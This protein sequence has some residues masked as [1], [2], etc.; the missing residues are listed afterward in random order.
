V[1]G[2]ALRVPP[3]RRLYAYAM[4]QTR[5][6]Q[7]YAAALVA[8]ANERDALEQ[9]MV[10]KSSE[11]AAV[12]EQRDALQQRMAAKSGEL[13]AAAEEREALEQRMAVKSSELT[14]AAEERDALEL[15]LY[16]LR[17]DH[18]R[19]AVRNRELS[20]ALQAAEARADQAV[21]AERAR[22]GVTSQE[23]SLL[24]VKLAGRMTLLSSEIGRLSHSPTAGGNRTTLYLDLL[25]RALTGG[26]GADVAIDPWTKGYDPEIGLVRMRN[27]RE[28]AERVIREGVPGDM[29]QAGVWRGGAGILMRGVLAAHGITDRTI[30][31]ADSFAG[32]PTADPETY[33]ADAGDHHAGYDARRV[34]S[35]DVQAN[36]RRYGL[37][38]RQV[39]FLKGWFA[40]TLSATPI[41]RLAILRIDGDMYAS[42]I[43]T[44]DAL[45]DKVEPGGYVIVDDYVLAGCRQAVNDFRDCHGIHDELNDVD[46]SA[47]FWRKA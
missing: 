44:L 16:V 35:E 27:L 31:V 21:A 19:A 47:V 6:N 17:S 9:R 11:L 18:Q 30:W 33:P 28:L 20:A 32:L 15:Q 43:Q 13:A 46:G 25:E 38:D 29:L 4:Q 37:L 8:A 23:L 22:A 41:D 45:Y 24:Y 10:V 7:D 26:L 39:R 14:S 2:A 40:E 3:I 36:F 1:R 12:A 34:S 42:T 5:M